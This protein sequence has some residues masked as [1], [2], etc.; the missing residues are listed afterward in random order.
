[1]TPRCRGTAITSKTDDSRSTILCEG[2][3]QGREE[4]EEEEGSRSGGSPIFPISKSRHGRCLI[5]RA[6]AIKI[7][8]RRQQQRGVIKDSKQ[9]LQNTYSTELYTSFYKCVNDELQ[10]SM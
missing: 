1:M 9:P 4:E 7:K 5:V 2:S 3:E 6:R 10:N 8:Y